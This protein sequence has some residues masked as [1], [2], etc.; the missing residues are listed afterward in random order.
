MGWEAIDLIGLDS[1]GLKNSELQNH[2]EK[3]IIITGFSWTSFVARLIAVG[4]DRITIRTI[5]E[6]EKT[7]NKQLDLHL[8]WIWDKW[9]ES[10]RVNQITTEWGEVLFQAPENSSKIEDL[11]LMNLIEQT[12]LS[13]INKL[14]TPRINVMDKNGWRLNRSDV[15]EQCIN[16]WLF[17]PKE[18]QWIVNSQIAKLVALNE[19][20]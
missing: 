11:E 6:D 2:K 10:L 3:N 16:T 7:N 18:I 17:D 19:S 5:S 9:R 15:K 4:K 12:R 1:E 14:L 8:I 20:E 13:L